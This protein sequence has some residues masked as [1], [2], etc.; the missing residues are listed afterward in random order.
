MFI[1][2]DLHYQTLSS[3]ISAYTDDNTSEHDWTDQIKSFM[4]L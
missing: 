4:V 3:I 1:D 2:F